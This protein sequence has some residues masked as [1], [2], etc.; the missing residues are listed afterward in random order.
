MKQAELEEK[1][2]VNFREGLRQ[3]KTDKFGLDL[4]KG[5]KDVMI[6]KILSLLSFISSITFKTKI[7]FLLLPASHFFH[8][9]LSF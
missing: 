4:L 2:T 5:G 3:V 7:Y 8:C 6:T 1:K 9:L